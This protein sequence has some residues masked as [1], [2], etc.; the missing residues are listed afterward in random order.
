ME[1]DLFF[2]GIRDSVELRKELLLSSKN[3]LDSL[4]KYE[5]YKVIKDQKFQ[6]VAELKRVF[7]ELLVL[8]KKLRGKMP[9]VPGKTPMLPGAKEPVEEEEQPIKQSQ[10]QPI[11]M[12]RQEKLSKLDML[13]QELAR[14]EERLGRLH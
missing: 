3:V 9:K 2:V 1:Q 4:R 10:K 13:E 11:K 14:V 5:Q 8:N 12:E 6:Y 7:D